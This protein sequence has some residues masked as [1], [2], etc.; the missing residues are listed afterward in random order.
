MKG[1][2]NWSLSFWKAVAATSSRPDAAF[3]WICA[4]LAAKSI[5]DLSSSGEFPELDALLSTEWD[6]LLSG[7][8]RKSVQVIEYKLLQEQKMIKGR[9]ITWLVFDHFR[10]SDVD[11]AM[12]N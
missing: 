7:E 3:I 1:F 8:F 10:L 12:L 2:R 11:G 4:V 6:K 5:D 9:Q